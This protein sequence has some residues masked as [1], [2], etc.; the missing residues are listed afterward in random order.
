MEYKR[1]FINILKDL[2]NF[3]DKILLNKSGDRICLSMADS[4]KIFYYDVS[5]SLDHFNIPAEDFP[6]YE[7]R[8][9]FNF[10]N[11]MQNPELFYADPYIIIAQGES[12]IKYKLANRAL[13]KKDVLQAVNFQ[14][15]QIELSLSAL[16]VSELVGYANLIKSEQVKI[17][18]NKDSLVFS[19]YSDAHSF[20]KKIPFN[21][22]N[23]FDFDFDFDVFTSLFTNL[24]KNRD[25]NMKIRLKE[26]DKGFVKLHL[27][28][29][30][31]DLN[32]HCG[33]V[34]PEL[35]RGT[36]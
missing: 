31:I 28:D 22:I 4:N 11:T 21:L 3:N 19:V 29:N 26:K 14:N 13:A 32:I 15:E 8:E 10:I 17:K 36:N 34:Y 23:D 25:W 24:P 9:F 6:F 2:A 7:Y 30:E 12:K 27:I 1:S 35:T 16:D 20:E 5:A 33:Y 18:G